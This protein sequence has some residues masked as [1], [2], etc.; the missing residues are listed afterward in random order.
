[1]VAIGSI[2]KSSHRIFRTRTLPRLRR[3]E[4]SGSEE[5]MNAILAQLEALGKLSYETLEVIAP[6]M[7][8]VRKGAPAHV[9][10]GLSVSVSRAFLR[11]RA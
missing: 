10:P 9:L 3:L 1:M 2:R 4:S 6:M 7:N 8:A 11:H 5:E